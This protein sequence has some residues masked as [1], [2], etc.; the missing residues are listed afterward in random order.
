VIVCGLFALFECFVFEM[1]MRDVGEMRGI[2][3]FVLWTTKLVAAWEEL[4]IEGARVS[5]S[6]LEGSSRRLGF[7]CN[8]TRDDSRGFESIPHNVISRV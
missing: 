4:R 5:G 8:V 3:I 2:F 6:E 7:I 1:K